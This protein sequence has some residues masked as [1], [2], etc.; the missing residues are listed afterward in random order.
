MGLPPQIYIIDTKDS[1]PRTLMVARTCLTFI[2]HCRCINGHKLM[3]DS[4]K[5][6]WHVEGNKLSYLQ[7]M[8]LLDTINIFFV[9]LWASDWTIYCIVN[10]W[11]YKK[12]SEEDKIPGI[13]Q[14]VCYKLKSVDKQIENKNVN[15]YEIIPHIVEWRMRMKVFHHRICMPYFVK[16]WSISEVS[17]FRIARCL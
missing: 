4:N 10:W 13:F 9:V 11:C 5:C 17:Y 3:S 6:V 16:S 14:I 1:T 12:I 8:N 2:L 15:R 7:K